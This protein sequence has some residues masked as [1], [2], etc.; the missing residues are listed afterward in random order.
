MEIYLDHA[1]ATPV[2]PEVVEAMKK[3][4][5]KEFGNPG[6]FHTIGL[7]AKEA[8]DEARE[9]I[10]KLINADK[11]E[12]IIFTGSGTES[13][14][15][16]IKGIARAN[17]E[18]GKHIITSK[19]E[20]EAVLETY[21][22]LEK[23][24]DFKITSLDV[25]KFGM[26]STEDLKKAIR[27]D[28]IL[29]SIMYANNEVGTILPIRQLAEIA[30]EKKIPFHTDACQAGGALNINVKELGADLMTLN[31]SKIYGPKGVGLLYV[32]TGLRILPL[33][34]GGGQE[35]KLRSGTQ[36][37]PGIVGFAKALEL[38]QAEKDQEN[39]RLIKLRDRLIK[40]IIKKIPKTFLNGHP[41]ER[42]PNNANLTFLDVE[43]EAMMLYLN[44]YGICASSGSACTSQSLDP[45]HVIL[46]LGLPYEVAHGTLRFTLGRKTTK[47]DIDKVL[48]VLPKI[49]ESLRKISPVNLTVEEVMNQK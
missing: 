22:Y 41:T 29:I 18:K 3:Y 16:A 6:S 44:E 1:A 33:I 26:V 20:H 9:T 35:F 19:I 24:E 45:S 36:N 10:K 14:N 13:I 47:K 30:K 4:F 5:S 17:K 21:R 49:V 43:G 15:L 38:A 37:V 48:E 2:R 25:D 23:Y 46:A 12:E 28:T 32:R 11:A 39:I 40:G 34:H 27:K 42:L 7:R 8:V 31:S